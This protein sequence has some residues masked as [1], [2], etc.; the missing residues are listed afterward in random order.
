M[1]TGRGERF[2]AKVGRGSH[3][4]LGGSTAAAASGGAP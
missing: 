3:R 1:L 4:P 2:R